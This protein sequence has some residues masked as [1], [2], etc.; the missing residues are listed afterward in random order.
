M[1][2]LEKP[3]N[4][5]EDRAYDE[6]R[7]RKGPR[8]SGGPASIDII[9][10]AFISK[11][12]GTMVVL[13]SVGLGCITQWAYA[14]IPVGVGFFIMGMGLGRY[15]IW[16]WYMGVFLLLPI[17][18]LGAIVATFLIGF[19]AITPLT[20][21]MLLS[22]LYVGWV[23]LSRGGRERYVRASEAMRK[24]RRDPNSVLGNAYGGK[25]KGRSRKGMK[26]KEKRRNDGF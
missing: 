6:S 5:E 24:A 4:S 12:F 18:V 15:K 1:T 10:L 11:I 8:R 13:F 9:N 22:G 25:R 7:R 3:M 2:L 26:N 20:L 16:A 23:L 14:G 17:S 19:G 21:S